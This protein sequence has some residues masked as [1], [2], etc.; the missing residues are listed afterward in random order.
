MALLH[1]LHQL[2]FKDLVV[3]HL[4]HQ[5]RAEAQADASLVQATAA[6]LGYAA[7]IESCDVR[8]QAGT[9]KIS[10][11]TAGRQARQAFFQRC[12]QQTDCSE[13]F[14]GHHADDQAE[15]VLMNV[16][17]GSGLR[18][19]GGMRFRTSLGGGLE[20]I[21]PLLDCPRE[22]LR[23]YA[24]FHGVK[25]Q[26]DASNT[27][28]DYLRNRLR[29]ELL[30]SASAMMQRNVQPS[31]GRLAQVAQAE[32]DFLAEYTAQRFPSATT[33]STT[34]LLAVPIAIQRRAVQAWLQYHQVP[35]ISL[36]LIEQV[37]AI[38]PSTAAIAK[39]NL[40][41]GRWARRR[42]GLLFVE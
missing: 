24:T 22:A 31:L 8:A 38:A 11:E 37:R 34:A 29:H 40:P 13:I 41:G 30:P 21:R 27:S 12:A 23:E 32:E 26:E 35:L 14:L 7:I 42:A 28:S 15:T 5:L 36:E 3:C 33:L 39:C 2:D 1:A 4:D 6:T 19:L 20:I 18:G 10:L 9:D 16:L 25:F 17:R